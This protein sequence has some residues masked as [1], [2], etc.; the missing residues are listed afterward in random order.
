MRRFAVRMVTIAFCAMAMISSTSTPAYSKLDPDVACDINKKKTVATYGACLLKAESKF[1]KKGD[2][3]K[4]VSALAKCDER[5]TAKF[6]KLEAK[7]VKAGSACPTVDDAD[8]VISF[9]SS[10]QQPVPSG[11]MAQ[12]STDDER[13]C[14]GG[15]LSAAAKAVSC[16]LKAEAGFQKKPYK[17]ER[18]AKGVSK[19][20]VE[21]RFVR[22][23]NRFACGTGTIDADSVDMTVRDCVQQTLDLFTPLLVDNGDGTITDTRTGLMWEQKVMLDDVVDYGNPHDADNGYRP[24]GACSISGRACQPDTP[25]QNACLTGLETKR[26]FD[27]CFICGAGEGTCLVDSI[28]PIFWE[29]LNDLN[30]SQFAGYNDWRIP[31]QEELGS[32]L[33]M[34]RDTPIID[35]LFHGPSCGVCADITDVNCGCTSSEYTTATVHRDPHTEDTESIRF[36]DLGGIFSSYSSGS[37]SV[38]AVRGGF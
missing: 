9:F 35:P 2:A 31:T 14:A 19:C 6:A 36:E 37:S 3:E 24:Y 29:W 13:K 26:D 10:C 34:Q 28:R 22:F 32:L 15:K 21:A 12:L 25:T 27:R 16:R 1:A 33:S 38:R 4:R 8:T 17:G 20:S 18:Y 7:A 23:E 30:A 11:L 5:L